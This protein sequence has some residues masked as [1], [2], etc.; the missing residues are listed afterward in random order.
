MTTITP[1]QSAAAWFQMKV[2]LCDLQP[3]VWRRIL[4]P[5]S[6]TLRELNAVIQ[7]AMGWAD[8]HLHMFDIGGR[9]F[10]MPDP[11]F[12]EPEEGE[13]DQKHMVAEVLAVGANFV[14]VYDFGD[15][16]R[17]AV[18]VEAAVPPPASPLHLPW[19][20]EPRCIGGARACPPED[21]GGVFG[22]LHYLEALAR[23]RQDSH[24]QWP[25]WVGGFEPEVF[26][27]DQANTLILANSVLYRER[28]WGFLD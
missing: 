18:G 12:P 20:D 9:R 6:L 27:V 16:W 17:H 7:G 2:E 4:V 1:R 10:E 11:D 19:I 3:E 24:E 5:G 8:S 25:P 14:Y 21:C 26:S 15:N 13:D 23:F 22:Y 28:G